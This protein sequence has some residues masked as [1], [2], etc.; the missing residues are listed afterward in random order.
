MKYV[1]MFIVATGMLLLIGCGNSGTPSDRSAQE[2]AP[3]ESSWESLAT[4]STP[5]WLLDAKFGIYAHW[6]VY[7]V[8]AFGSEWYAKWMYDESTRFYDHH[9]HTYGDP[10]AFGYKE[11]IPMFKAEKY[12]PEEW[13]DL[14][15]GSGARFAG[16]AVVHHDGFC[17]WDS[18][19]T[20]WNSMDMGP[21]RDLFGEL[22]HALR[23]KED[24][25]IVS[26]FHHIRTFDWYLPYKRRFYD[27][28]DQELRKHCI[29]K[30]WDIFDPEYADL[31][32]NQETGKQEDF[33]REWNNKIREVISNYQPDLIWFD[34]GTFR[35][36]VNEK[37]VMDLLT[38]Y[39]NKET[40]WNKQVE[41]LNKLPVSMQFNFPEEIGM[42]TFEEGRD[43]G[44]FIEG[45]WIDDMKISHS[46]WGYVEG[47]TYKEP[48]VIIDG[49]IDRVSRG[50][51]LVLS[52]CPKADGTIGQEQQD[53]LKAIGNWLSINGEAIY[54]TRKWKIQSEGDIEKLLTQQAHPKWDFSACTAEDIRFTTKN[55]AL[56]AMVLGVPDTE[57]ILIQ[58][59]GSG[60]EISSKGIRRISLLGS[61]ET[62]EWERKEGGLEIH[63]P[64]AAP[65]PFALAFKIEVKG[66]LS[67]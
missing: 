27:P 42:R 3:Y 17:L 44:E 56:Y 14:I 31:Y 6:G 15:A 41:I 16:F 11:F 49:L 4:H 63:T 57:K 48:D 35:D 13:A 36:S 47:Q 58:S 50:G 26:T 51:G 12:D 19:Q 38:F 24:M 28:V 52:L 7:S 55:N 20:R 18:E 67:M 30:D 54:G 66:K 22:V 33:I 5:E 29:S 8:P 1:S 34:G 40:E 9:V 64:S 2:P 61:D 45:N 10:S 60:T 62:I 53:I 46:S 25:R 65:S 39:Y 59:L 37:I 21:H 32:W 43:R 23:K